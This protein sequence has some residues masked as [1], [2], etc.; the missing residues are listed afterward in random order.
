MKFN[1]SWENFIL[2]N[3]VWLFILCVIAKNI[4]L[5]EQAGSLLLGAFILTIVIDIKAYIVWKERKKN[6]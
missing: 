6:D 3:V 2:L 5:K 4:E 1:V